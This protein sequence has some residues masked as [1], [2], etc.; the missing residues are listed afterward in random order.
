VN[1]LLF[2]I[3]AA[4]LIASSLGVVLARSLW[5]AAYSL[6]AALVTTAVFYLLLSAPLVAAVQILLYTGGVLTLV[7]FALVMTE[8]PERPVGWRRPVQAAA[9]ASLVFA[10]LASFAL[11]AGDPAPGPK[12]ASGNE[13]GVA[14]FTTYLVPFELLSLL[15]LA[16][17][18]GALAIARR[19]EGR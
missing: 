5:R 8:R 15:L 16:A 10:A 2:S 1:D 13:A 18:F 12:L 19:E 11:R 17:I 9:A 14:V 3:L 4:V 6:A 7:V